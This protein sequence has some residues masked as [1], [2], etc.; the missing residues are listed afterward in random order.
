MRGKSYRMKILIV[1]NSYGRYSGEEAVVDRM[2]AMFRS[3]G[4]EVALLRRTT[5][6]ARNTMGGK[7]RGFFCGLYSPDGVKAMREALKRERPDVVNIHNLY[8]FISPAALFECRKVGVPVVMTVHNFRLICPTGLFMRNGQPCE[9]CLQRGNEWGCVQHNCEQSWLKSIGYAARNAVARRSGAYRKCVTRF[10]CITD[11]QRQKLTE[12]GFEPERLTVIPNVVDA[13]ESYTPTPGDYV[14]YLGR[15]S[16]EKGYDL[17]IEVARR[18]PEIRFRFAGAQR[19]QT[20]ETLPNNVELTGYLTGDDLQTFIR[21]CRFVAMP[22][23]WYEGFPMVILENAQYG[24]PTIGPDHGGFTDIIGKGE[25]AIGRLFHPGDVDDLEKQVV[26]LWNAPEECARLGSKAFEKLT[27]DYCS[28]TAARQW[29][30]LLEEI[31]A[32][33]KS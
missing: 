8:P 32:K 33:K 5:E 16:Y 12:A 17:L 2:S 26:T 20:T 10:V 25:T 3:Q 22:S 31:V 29:A 4:H 1:H 6:E 19:A 7:V 14:A 15:V 23:R 30:T 21:Q 27:R 11:F 18:H 13:L 28:K 9:L 24:K